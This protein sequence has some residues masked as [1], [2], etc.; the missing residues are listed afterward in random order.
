VA[1]NKNGL[2]VEFNSKKLKAWSGNIGVVM[3]ANKMAHPRMEKLDFLCMNSQL[4]SCLGLNLKSWSNT[5]YWHVYKPRL[6]WW[7]KRILKM[8]EMMVE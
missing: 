3:C 6:T 1:T 5:I 7:L 8:K 4:M 2:G